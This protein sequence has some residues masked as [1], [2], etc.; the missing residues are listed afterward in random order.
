MSSSES[1]TEWINELRRGEPQAAQKLWQAYVERLIHLARKHLR[2]SPR[3][4][5]DEEDVVVAAFA[6]FC[7]AVK[8]GRFSR[9]EDR[10]D[11]WQVLSVL[12]ERRAIDQM[13]QQY[14]E[15]RGGGEVHGESVFAG[16]ESD[17]S[18]GVGLGGI[19]DTEPTPKTAA[20]AAEQFRLLL[21]ALN[22]DELRE[23]ALAKMEGHSIEELTALLGMSRRTVERRLSLI[24]R[25]WEETLSD[26]SE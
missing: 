15:R 25:I 23:I 22:D 11:L 4:S 14:A 19:A 13:R 8:A 1:V 20:L 5:A 21:D 9:L 26:R 12:T 3:R 7:E 24:R 10:N 2:T 17:A 6:S 18:P 16:L